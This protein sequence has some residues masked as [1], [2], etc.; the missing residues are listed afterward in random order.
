MKVYKDGKFHLQG[1]GPEHYS[2]T[3]QDVFHNDSSY[4]L[5][6]QKLVALLVC[7]FPPLMRDTAFVCSEFGFHP[8]WLCR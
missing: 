6:V 1:P 7:L 4:N 3:M 2:M 5:W 8:Q